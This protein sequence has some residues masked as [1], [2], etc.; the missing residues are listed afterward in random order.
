M[1]EGDLAPRPGR[2]G[3]PEP[4]P[5]DRLDPG[6]GVGPD[7]GPDGQWLHERVWYDIDLETISPYDVW[8]PDS[9]TWAMTVDWARVND[10][11]RN[12][13]DAYPANDLHV[14]LNSAHAEATL[15]AV[16]R[17]G[18]WSLY[19]EPIFA[20]PDQ[21]T[22]GGHRIT[23]M[24]TQGLRWALGQCHPDDV[25]TPGIPELHVYLRD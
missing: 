2:T 19:A 17:L 22:S 4:W 11:V 3:S 21:I 18:L 23:A 20:T 1:A 12:H 7:F 14:A 16:D 5:P 25:G 15:T 10:L 8:K 6:P 9:V 24:R 13:L